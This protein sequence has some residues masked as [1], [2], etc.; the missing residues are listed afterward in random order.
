VR[1]ARS[2]SLV[3]AAA[4]I[5]VGALC[6]A[7]VE[8]V[9][10]LAPPPAPWV[11]LLFPGVAL[12]YV[13]VGLGSWLRRPSSAL[14]PLL[15]FGGGCLFLG[16]FYNMGS[17]WL[18]AIAAVTATVILALIIHLLLGFPTGRLHDPTTRLVVAAA[19]MVSLVLQAPLYL[20]ASAGKLSIADRH[21]LAQL[22]LQVQRGVGACVVVAACW[23]LA[24]RIRDADAPRRRVLLPLTIYGI[25]AL[26]TIP[27]SS[28]LADLWGG[29]TLTQAAVELIALG[30]VPVSFVVAASRGGFA[31]TTDLAELG[32]WLGA[33][34]VE[35]PALR[36]A[37]AITLGDPSLELLFAL[38]DGGGALVDGRGVEA[39]RPPGDDRA[40]GVVDVDLAGEPVGAIVYDALLLDRVD[41]VREAGR[42]V[43]L[44][45][46]RER[47]TA[48]L[49]ASRAR[50]AAAADDERR[51]IARDLHDGLQSRLVFL[52]IQAATGADPA[53]LHA[54]IEGAIDDLRELVDGVMPAL[55]TAR[56]LPAAVADLADRLPSPIALRVGGLDERLAPAVESAAF[57]VVS[58]AVVNAVKH[59]GP[60]GLTIALER[61]DGHLRVAIADRGSGAVRLDGEGI[62]GM[63]DRVA[64]LDGTLTVDARPGQGTRVE[65]VIP[66]TAPETSVLSSQGD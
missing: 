64:V 54:G 23:L 63:V 12:V 60:D 58:E 45:V 26:L 13:A 17:E 44:A 16:G 5:G 43:A 62:R 10:I 6:G 42:V 28:A 49:R 4:L 36:D 19:Y 20:F 27:V 53:T 14:G 33:G 39:A 15:V 65:A 18:A 52:K 48:S 2:R 35:R 41:E 32:A 3:A 51:R 25:L 50:I 40:R 11:A 30:L 1:V 55:L 34:E 57:F 59:A 31:R 8:V 61:A 24:R 29:A 56:G 7:V 9:F 66:V 22:G 46:D 38:P 37:L 47:L 21:G